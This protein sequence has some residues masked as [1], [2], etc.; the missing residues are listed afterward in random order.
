MPSS[1]AFQFQTNATDVMFE[2]KKRNLS[3]IQTWAFTFSYASLERAF[4]FSDV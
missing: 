1:I 4:K 2:V 3:A